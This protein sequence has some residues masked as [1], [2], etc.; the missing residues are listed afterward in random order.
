MISFAK[1]LTKNRNF[2]N[3]SIFTI[4]LL[5]VLF[6]LKD[7]SSCSQLKCLSM[8]RLDQYQIK[9]IY[10]DDGSVFR[11]LY[12]LNNEFMRVEVKS[13]I[14]SGEAEARINSQLTRIEGLFEKAVSPYP[15]EISDAIECGEEYVPNPLTEEVN[16]LEIHYFTAYLNQRLVSG[17]CTEDQAIYKEVF[18]LFHC[19]KSKHLYQIELIAPASEFNAKEVTYNEMLNSINCR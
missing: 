19:Q 14:A 1:K 17:A 18:I 15:G 12:F 13:E 6:F 3:F 8:T 9:E 7:F 10:Q 2:F 16:Q 11:A 5:L 4:A